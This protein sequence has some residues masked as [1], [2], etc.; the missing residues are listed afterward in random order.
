MPVAAVI[1]FQ[2]E[3]R[4]LAAVLYPIDGYPAGIGHDLAEWVDSSQRNVINELSVEIISSLH[5]QADSVRLLPADV[6]SSWRGYL[7]C[8][9]SLDG[10][11][12]ISIEHDGE[13][14]FSGS[15]ADCLQFVSRNSVI[16]AAIQPNQSRQMHLKED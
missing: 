7:Y 8:V 2:E 10:C 11:L 9:N 16:M 6:V 3:V 12:F 5:N 1:V 14:M 15:G 4:Q 13:I